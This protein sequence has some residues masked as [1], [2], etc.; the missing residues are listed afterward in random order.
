MWYT[1]PS[2]SS[3]KLSASITVDA[4][5]IKLHST[6]SYPLLV[7]T[8]VISLASSYVAV[9]PA[10]TSAA[11]FVLNT[12]P[13]VFA[14]QIAYKVTSPSFSEVRLSLI[15]S[16]RSYVFTLAVVPHPVSV[17]PTLLKFDPSSNVVAVS[18]VAV[19]SAV[20]PLP[21][22]ASN[23]IVYVFAVTVTPISTSPAVKYSYV[24]SSLVPSSTN[25]SVH[26]VKWYP[27]A[28]STSNSTSVSNTTSY[29]DPATTSVTPSPLALI[30]TLFKFFVSVIV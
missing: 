29:S 10:T 15:S 18:Y 11:P 28:T 30:V 27:V 8:A 1:P 20:T 2:L 19:M 14:L 6:K 7:T 24:N 16:P 9:N 5:L 22:F 21:V 4:P 13:Y 3:S 17:Y 26:L 12:T 25:P 23:T